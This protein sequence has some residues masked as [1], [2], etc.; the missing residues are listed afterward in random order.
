M[1]PFPNWP[2]QRRRYVE[3]LTAL[4]TQ[5]HSAQRVGFFR[6]TL[7]PLARSIPLGVWFIRT[8]DG[9]D[10]ADPVQAAEGRRVFELHLPRERP[11]AGSGAGVATSRRRGGSVANSRT[12]LSVLLAAATLVVFVVVIAMGGALRAGLAPWPG[13]AVAV[14]AIAAFAFSRGRRSLI[15]AALLGA[16]GLVGLVYGLIRTEFLTDSAFPG[17]IFGI[18][19]GLQILGLAL[20]EAV[21]AIRDRRSA[22]T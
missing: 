16:S 1:L 2:S 14:L 4:L 9:V 18:I 10:L 15:V 19:L 17:P 12:A 22:T 20:A 11:P 3:E 8:V 6:D 5:F 7:G 13:I 21:G